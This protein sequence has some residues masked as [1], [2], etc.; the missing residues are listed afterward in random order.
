MASPPTGPSDELYRARRRR[1]HHHRRRSKSVLPIALGSLAVILI[2]GATYWYFLAYRPA[3]PSRPDAKVKQE[4]KDRMALV[5][6]VNQVLSQTGKDLPASD[7]VVGSASLENRA[8]KIFLAGTLENRS[9]RAYLRVHIIFDT[10]DQDHNPAGQVEGDVGVVQ[11]GKNAS[12]EIGP[13]SPD[14]RTWIVH[15]ITAGQ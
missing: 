9:N 8:G 3:D 13:V 12:F 14:A 6:A 5:A 4:S 11:P 2:S 15:S 1:R 7:L 10:T